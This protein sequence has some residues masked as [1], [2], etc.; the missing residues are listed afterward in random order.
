MQNKNSYIYS[1]TYAHI[2]RLFVD[3]ITIALIEFDSEEE[4]AL[5]FTATVT[6][7]GGAGKGPAAK[8]CGGAASFNTCRSFGNEIVPRQLAVKSNGEGEDQSAKRSVLSCAFLVRREEERTS[9]VA[10]GEER[11]YLIPWV[12]A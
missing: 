11:V 2:D 7:I 6:V 9:L 1:N 10:R 3:P 5:I 12:A 4:R 8:V